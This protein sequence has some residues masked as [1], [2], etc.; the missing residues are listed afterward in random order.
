MDWPTK[1]MLAGVA[2]MVAG[3]GYVLSR[4]WWHCTHPSTAYCAERCPTRNTQLV[5]GLTCVYY[6][7]CVVKP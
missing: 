1:A 4:D 6:C 2:I 3:F 5:D 7:D